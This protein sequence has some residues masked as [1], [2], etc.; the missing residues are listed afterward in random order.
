MGADGRGSL[1]GRGTGSKRQ[2]VWRQKGLGPSFK[3]AWSPWHT[4]LVDESGERQWLHVAK[5]LREAQDQGSAGGVRQVEVPEHRRQGHKGCFGPVGRL[6]GG[7]D[8]SHDGFAILERRAIGGLQVVVRLHGAQ[9]RERGRYEAVGA[10]RRRARERQGLAEI[11]KDGVQQGE[12][13]PGPQVMQL[14]EQPLGRLLG[15]RLRQSVTIQL[16]Y[17]CEC[18]RQEPR[19]ALRPGVCD[20][21]RGEGNSVGVQGPRQRTRCGLWRLHIGQATNA[22]GNGERG[23]ASLSACVHH[24]PASAPKADGK[25]WPRNGASSAC[26]TIFFISAPDAVRR[27]AAGGREDRERR[28]WRTLSSVAAGAFSPLFSWSMMAAIGVGKR[29]GRAPE[30]SGLRCNVYQKK[31]CRPPAGLLPHNPMIALRSPPRLRKR[32]DDPS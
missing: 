3:L 16:T 28:A 29:V 2:Q 10:R 31:A 23:K 4:Y 25:N 19:P 5:A 18:A 22:C 6:Q 13:A 26:S 24:G 21:G 1:R 20:S 32:Q 15:R 12:E 8:V 30:R 17:Q 9:V 11:R 27:T 7:D 14:G